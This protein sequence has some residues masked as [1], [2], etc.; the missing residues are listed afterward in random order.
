ML[1]FFLVRCQPI[2]SAPSGGE[3]DIDSGGYSCGAPPLPIPNREV[4]PARADGTAPQSG[5]V[6]R[7]RLGEGLPSG[8]P[9]GRFLFFCRESRV[10]SQESRV[11]GR[12]S[13]VESQGSRVESR[14]SMLNVQ[15]SMLNVQCSMAN[16]QCSMFNVQCSSLFIFLLLLSQKN[17]IT[18]YLQIFVLCHFLPEHIL[19]SKVSTG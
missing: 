1:C 18:L 15:C 9:E 16:V 17:R 14:E 11:K 2:P 8:P 6:G 5:R 3:E 19:L 4:K 13:R 7:R 12:E 10:K